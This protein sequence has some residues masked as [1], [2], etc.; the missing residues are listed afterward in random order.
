MI[1]LF[2]CGEIYLF[3]GFLVGLGAQ[4]RCSVSA[5]VAS[6]VCCSVQR[7]DTVVGLYRV[8]YV[9]V[10]FFTSNH[11]RCTGECVFTVGGRFFPRWC[12]SIVV[13]SLVFSWKLLV[14]LSCG[15]I[16]VWSG[17]WIAESWWNWFVVRGVYSSN[18]KPDPP[19]ETVSPDCLQGLRL[20]QSLRERF[21]PG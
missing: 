5:V 7:S 13:H 20:S 4:T 11:V 18:N 14:V 17:R 21:R 15:Q 12:G 19:A 8:V 1:W 9:R 2:G 16:L 3:F 6:S 10:S